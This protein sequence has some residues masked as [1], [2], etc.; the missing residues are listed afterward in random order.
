MLRLQPLAIED[1]PEVMR[2]ER[3]PFCAGMVGAFSR[4]KH[5]AEMT[6]PDARYAGFRA[7][8][9]LAGFAILQDFR[10]PV[11][12]LRRIVVAVPGRGV[13]TDLLRAVMT[14]VF[15]TTPAAGLRLHVRGDNARAPAASTCAKVSPT[16]L[17]T[18]AAIACRLRASAGCACARRA[19]SRA[20]RINRFTATNPSGHT[21]ISQMRQ[22]TL[23]VVPS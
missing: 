18:P 5:A 7:G 9:A 17:P 8:A 21:S 16:P 4:E 22:L 23:V 12:R 19:A 2:L 13:G 20:W 6:S 11:V 10:Q 14:W 15:D 1:I 3:L